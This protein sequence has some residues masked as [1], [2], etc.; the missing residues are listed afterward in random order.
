MTGKGESSARE[1]YEAYRKGEIDAA[2]V[3]KRA[4]DWYAAHRASLSKPQ[5]KT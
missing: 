3:G 5:K 4:Q 1:T 2:Q